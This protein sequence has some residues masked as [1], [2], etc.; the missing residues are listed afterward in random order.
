MTARFI[1]VEGIEVA[2]KSTNIAYIKPG[3]PEAKKN[4]V[5]ARGHG[6]G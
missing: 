2:G 5:V 4:V 6:V 1:T 3:L